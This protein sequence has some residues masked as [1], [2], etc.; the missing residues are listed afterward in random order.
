MLWRECEERLYSIYSP[1]SNLLPA[2]SPTFS[3]TTVMLPSNQTPTQ[4]GTNPLLHI[5]TSKRLER[6]TREQ[7]SEAIKFNILI[8]QVEVSGRTVTTL[9]RVL[10]P[11]Q[12]SVL[13]RSFLYP[14]CRPNCSP[15]FSPSCTRT[16]APHC[17]ITKSTNSLPLYPKAIDGFDERDWPILS[18]K[19]DKLD[20]KDSGN[21]CL[22]LK[23]GLKETADLQITTNDTNK[24]SED[25]ILR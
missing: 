11:S 3:S 9:R 25:V 16:L 2:Q 15:F 22:S 6:G 10:F 12:T 7:G 18:R 5:V 24:G 13:T 14:F 4:G 21:D 17:A 23:E 1:V 20:R 8:L 19:V